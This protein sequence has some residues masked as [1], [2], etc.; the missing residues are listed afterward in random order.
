MTHFH[1]RPNQN[2]Y[3]KCSKDIYYNNNA[4]QHII[5]HSPQSSSHPNIL[6]INS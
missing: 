5:T 6:T 1:K 2:N 4:Y 3:Q